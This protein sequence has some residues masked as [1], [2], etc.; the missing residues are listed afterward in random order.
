MCIATKSD[1]GEKISV[2]LP[3][4]FGGSQIAAVSSSV[5]TVAIRRLKGADQSG[6][7]VL[8]LVSAASPLP[9]I[10]DVLALRVDDSIFEDV[11]WAGTVPIRGDQEIK[12]IVAEDS[13]ELRCGK[14]SIVLYRDGRIVVKGTRVTSR[15]SG[16]NKIRGSSVSI[17]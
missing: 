11:Q 14:S 7:P 12:T 17:N 5:S 3:S 10:V 13:L 1:C 16:E 4:A 2:E 8:V 6:V 9:V 15:A